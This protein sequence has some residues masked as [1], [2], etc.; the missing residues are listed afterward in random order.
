[1]RVSKLTRLHFSLLIFVR[2]LQR[3]SRL[4]VHIKMTLIHGP[5]PDPVAW[6]RYARGSFRLDQI[7]GTF[8][9]LWIQGC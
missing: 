4:L 7:L 1:M 8:W 5:A 3:V 2:Y 6:T 9:S